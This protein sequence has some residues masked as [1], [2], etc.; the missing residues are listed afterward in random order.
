MEANDPDQQKTNGLWEKIIAQ[1]KKHPK[2][3]WVASAIIIIILIYGGLGN[4]PP[5]YVIKEAIL[6]NTTPYK[7]IRVDKTNVI[8]SF[9]VEYRGETYYCVEVN[10][11]V[12][13]EDN[14]GKRVAK[15]KW[16][17]PHRLSLVKRG[18]SWYAINGWVK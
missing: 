1:Y 4:K 5:D 14:N 3:F 11:L 15:N 2:L 17:L 10:P 13:Y 16:L 8:N 7:N 12:T 6:R 18:N 9:T